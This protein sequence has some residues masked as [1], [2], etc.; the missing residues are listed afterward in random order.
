MIL[1]ISLTRSSSGDLPL[2]SRKFSRAPLL[3]ALFLVLL[4]TAC[5]T[6]KQQQAARS[7]KANK[8]YASLEV[9]SEHLRKG[10]THS[11]VNSLLGDPDYSPITGQEYYSSDRRAAVEETGAEH[12]VGLVTDYRDNQGKPTGRLQTFRLV[13]IGE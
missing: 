5:D 2:P 13:P 4:S 7:Y 8:D 11:E 3:F 1:G 6:Q 12:P 9:L 10:M